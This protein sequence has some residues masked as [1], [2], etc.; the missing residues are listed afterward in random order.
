M[1]VNPFGDR[2]SISLPYLLLIAA[3][4]FFGFSVVAGTPIFASDEYVYFIS[5]KFSSD[6]QMIHERDPSLQQ[7]TNVLYFSIVRFFYNVFNEQFVIG[8]RLVHIAEYLTAAVVLFKTVSPTLGRNYSVLGVCAFLLLPSQIYIYAV[9]PEVE[10]VLLSSILGYVMVRGYTSRPYLACVLAGVLVAVA[11]LIKPHALAIMLAVIGAIAVYRI[12]IDKTGY[13]KRSAFHV[14]IFIVFAYLT[15]VLIWGM[16]SG[17]WSFNPSNALGLSFYG[18]YI[19]PASG[20]V[21][22][23]GKIIL[24]GLYFSLHAVVICMV[25]APVIYW[26]VAGTFRGLSRPADSLSSESAKLMLAVFALALIGVHVAM[27]AWFTAGAALLKDSEAF[28]LHGRYLGPAIVLLPGLYFYAVAQCPEKNRK[29]MLGISLLAVV[30]SLF[31]VNGLIKIYP[32]DNPLL[33]AFFNSKN[34]YLWNYNSQ[35][36]HWGY[37]LYAGLLAGIVYCVSRTRLFIRGYTI[38]L[39]AI[40]VVGLLQNY[41]WLVKHLSNNKDVSSKTR[42]LGQL[43]NA[44]DY[45]DGVLVSQERFGRESYALFNLGKAVRPLDRL[46]GSVITGQDIAGADWLVVDGDY[47]LQMKTTLIAD[48]KPLRFYLIE[49]EGTLAAGEKISIDLKKAGNRSVFRGFNE[50]EEWGVWTSE[51]EASIKLSKEVS[52]KLKVKISGWA[53]KE[54]TVEPVEIRIGGTVT[55]IKMSDVREDY[56]FSVDVKEPT[57]HILVS[58]KPLKPLGSTRALG[59]ALSSL[60]VEVISVH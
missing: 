23:L 46:P 41:S 22:L 14:L 9:M 57:Q 35:F 43:I 60:S 49:S 45:G 33:F 13:L 21:T 29:L 34:W 6:L 54:N 3:M 28:R 37:V 1:I 40:L 8:Y 32:W 7:L 59:V 20:K 18:Q 15:T 4:L 12:S 24:F 31:L 47:D 55:P 58:S 51:R 2:F 36:G 39:F 5:G 27:T 25:F 16:L 48:L 10:L 38:F 17:V 50:A 19:E 56:E 44:G 11:I 30:L 26:A 53:L 42:V 52:G